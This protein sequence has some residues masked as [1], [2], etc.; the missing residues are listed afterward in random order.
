MFEIVAVYVNFART[1]SYLAR[2][3]AHSVRFA[4]TVPGC[5]TALVGKKFRITFTG[6]LLPPTATDMD[7]Q[8][9]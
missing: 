7:G 8:P 9:S 5:A 1:I 3:A 4:E 2:L 6:A